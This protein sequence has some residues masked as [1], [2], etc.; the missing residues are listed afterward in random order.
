M[1][2]RKSDM[3]WFGRSRV[4]NQIISLTPWQ[5]KFAVIAP[6]IRGSKSSRNSQRLVRGSWCRKQAEFVILVFNDVS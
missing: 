2:T 1:R 5:D 6:S 3:R 4:S